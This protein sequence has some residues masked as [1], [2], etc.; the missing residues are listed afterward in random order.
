M[1][2]Y[3]GGFQE[4][5][6][7]WLESNG[8]K[9]LEDEYYWE[10]P[11]KNGTVS[12]IYTEKGIL[13]TIHEAV[14]H[15]YPKCYEKTAEKAFIGAFEQLSKA[16]KSVDDT[17]AFLFRKFKPECGNDEHKKN[18]NHEKEEYDDL[19]KKYETLVE[20]IA[21]CRICGRK[22]KEFFA[23]ETIGLACE[24]DFSNNV[25]T[26]ICKLHST[27]KDNIENV[28][29]IIALIEAWNAKQIIK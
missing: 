26:T 27:I 16:M 28:K 25:Q 20:N 12:I 24:N 9:Y 4:Q 23:G 22:P 1:T 18:V 15:E 10:L 11:I 2:E 8:F 29:T 21:P 14:L 3:K 5:D 13:C 6:V 17:Y 7:T 19:C